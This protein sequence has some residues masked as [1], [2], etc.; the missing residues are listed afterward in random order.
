MKSTL[1]YKMIGFKI[2]FFFTFK[3]LAH[4]LVLL[5]SADFFMRAIN[6]VTSVKVSEIRFVTVLLSQPIML[7]ANYKCQI[8]VDNLFLKSG[9]ATIKTI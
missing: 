8:Q 4:L 6:K 7:S 3:L 9:N 5:K 1:V 2:A